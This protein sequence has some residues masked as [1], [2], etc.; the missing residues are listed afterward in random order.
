MKG[1]SSDGEDVKIKNKLPVSSRINIMELCILLF[2]AYVLL[3]SYN[4]SSSLILDA[5][6]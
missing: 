1:T 2:L 6:R 4:V 3:S 5:H